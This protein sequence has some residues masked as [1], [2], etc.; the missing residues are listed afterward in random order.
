MNTAIPRLNVTRCSNSASSSFAP[1]PNTLSQT[2]QFERPKKPEDVFRVAAF[3][4]SGAHP[5]RILLKFW[6]RV[7]LRKLRN[8]SL[9]V[10][11]EGHDGCVVGWRAWADCS[12]LRG[13][14]GQWLERAVSSNWIRTCEDACLLWR[15][16]EGEEKV[17]SQDFSARFLLVILSGTRSSPPVLSDMMIQMT[18]LQFK[19]ECLPLRMPFVCNFS[20]LCTFLVHT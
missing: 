5:H 12:W 11:G 19:R 10:W 4:W 7:P 17:I 6:S 9:W 3:P 20:I 8:L 2:R 14:L 13:V 1:R 15:A 18:C 16:S